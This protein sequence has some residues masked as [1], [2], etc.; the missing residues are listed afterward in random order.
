MPA[1]EPPS[2][3]WAVDLAL[4]SQQFVAPANDAPVNAELPLHAASWVHMAKGW[5]LGGLLATTL[6]LRQ[7]EQVNVLYPDGSHEALTLSE[8]PQ[9]HARGGDP[10]GTFTTFHIP[11]EPTWPGATRQHEA[12]LQQMRD[13]GFEF[14]GDDEDGA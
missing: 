6:D 11:G 8:P 2:E 14:E 5:A 10:R 3:P 12:M 4:T 9:I 1:N 7:V 13:E